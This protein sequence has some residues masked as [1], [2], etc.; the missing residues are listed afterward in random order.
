MSLKIAL[1]CGSVATVVGGSYGAYYLLQEKTIE[2]E[3][4]SRNLKLIKTDDDYQIAFREEKDTPAF[5]TLLNSIN[6][7]GEEAITSNSV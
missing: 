5:I 2:N 7:T 1:T 3:L 6:K 4:T